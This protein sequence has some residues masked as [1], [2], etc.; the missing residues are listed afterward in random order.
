MKNACPYC[1][2][3]KPQDEIRAVPEASSTV[4]G[5][6]SAAKALS[7]MNLQMIVGAVL[8]V[9]IVVAVIALISVNVGS[10]VQETAEIEVA[11]QEEQEEM[12]AATAVP[13]NTPEPTP[14][15]TP[16]PTVTSITITFMGS[17][18]DGFMEQ[19]GDEIQLGTTYYPANIEDV[20]VEWSSSDDS[21]ASVS[22]DGLVT[23]NS[24]GYCTISASIGTTTQSIDVWVE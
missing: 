21:I 13:T 22:E 23:L 11:Q 5:S 6:S 2:E 3:E 18:T 1:G 14:S 7:S 20:V 4:R 12:A 10:R 17:S 15:P 24:S 19:V 16:E 8:L 9:L